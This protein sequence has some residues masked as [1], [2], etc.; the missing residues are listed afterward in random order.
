[1][2]TREAMNQ[3]KRF[4]DQVL[5]EFSPVE[6]VLYGSY[7]EGSQTELSDIDV[8]VI[9]DEFSGNSFEADNRLWEIAWS[10]DGFVEPVLLESRKDRSGFVS[11]VR[12]H[13]IV[14]YQAGA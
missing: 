13:G 5:R 9:F 4:V 8:A 1:M 14:L 6:I 12:K 2:D 3:A 10:T 7:A 11:E